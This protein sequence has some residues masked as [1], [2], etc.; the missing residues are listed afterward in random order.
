[1]VRM[2][3]AQQH[4]LFETELLRVVDYR[5]RGHDGVAEQ[6]QEHEIVLPRS[7][8][9]VRRDASGLCVADAN[10]VLFFHR[11]QTFDIHHPHPGGDRSTDF[12]LKGNAAHDLVRHFDPRVEDHWER[13]FPTSGFTLRRPASGLALSRL[14]AAARSAPQEALLLEELALLL[15]GSI[16][17]Q[18]FGVR[19][20]AG[21]G[22]EGESTADHREAAAR[23][24]LLLRQELSRKLSLQ[25]LADQAGYSPY[26]LCRLFKRQTGL[27]IHRYLQ[28]LRL[29]ESLDLL[30]EFPQRSV[31]EIA[32]GLGFAS[33]SHFTTA[34][35]GHFALPPRAFRQGPN[36]QTLQELRKILK[37]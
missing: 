21:V 2:P 5:C 18:A 26:H 35:R 10:H 4:L 20:G 13:P 9:Y 27:S 6:A 36:G 37:D 15:L 31:A 32:H 28:Q 23:V 8:S 3:A 34:F 33:H 25:E 17:R 11:G 7:G 19:Q 29:L 16:L 1:M 24:K 12:A 30:V 22:R 14:T